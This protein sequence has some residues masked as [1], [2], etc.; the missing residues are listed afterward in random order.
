MR[1]R[2]RAAEYLANLVVLL[3][4]ERLLQRLNAL[5]AGMLQ[6]LL[7]RGEPVVRPLAEQRE[8]AQ[9]RVDG[10]AQA[11]VDHYL[12]Q[13]VA[14]DRA[15]LLVLHGIERV[16]AVAVLRG[17]HQL[18]RLLGGG[19]SGGGGSAVLS[20]L[21]VSDDVVSVPEVSVFP[22]SSDDAA[23]PTV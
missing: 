2:D 10:P 17:D 20:E 14:G 22:L 1:R 15:D 18:H 8:A 9:R 21:S 6:C 23:P 4:G 11:V 13:A 5:G 3:G 12:V 16:A 19:G 7:R